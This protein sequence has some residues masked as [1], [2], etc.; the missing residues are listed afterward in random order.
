VPS[1]T[2]G[3]CLSGTAAEAVGNERVK[4]TITEPDYWLLGPLLL[5]KHW[6]D[7]LSSVDFTICLFDWSIKTKWASKSKICRVCMRKSKTKRGSLP[8]ATLLTA[9]AR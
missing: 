3:L 6:D 1:L 9:N 5:P 2:S 7:R 4:W 8:Q